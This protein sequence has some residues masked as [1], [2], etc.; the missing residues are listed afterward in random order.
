[1]NISKPSGGSSAYILILRTCIIRAFFTLYQGSKN[2]ASLVAEL[3]GH[4]RKGLPCAVGGWALV[5]HFTQLGLV[6]RGQS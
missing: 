4:G 6:A 1:M 5:R 3:G 2:C